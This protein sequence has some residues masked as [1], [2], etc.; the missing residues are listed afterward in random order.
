MKYILSDQKGSP[1][2]QEAGKRIIETV[3]KTGNAVGSVQA[4]V[5]QSRQQRTQIHSI[6][7]SSVHEIFVM[8]NNF[9]VLYMQNQEYKHA[10]VLL[11]CAIQINRNYQ[12]VT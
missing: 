5:Q 1:K 2:W 6:D 3:V 11:Q 8:I 7:N 9:A 10:F 4:M 12:N